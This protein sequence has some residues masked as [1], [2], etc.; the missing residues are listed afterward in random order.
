MTPK[1][2][3]FNALNDRPIDRTPTFC[4]G[5]SQTVTVESMEAIGVYWP[6]AHSDP[7]MMAELSASTYDLTGLEIA[8]VPYC[9]SVEA[10]ALGCHTDF[11]TRRDSIPQ[12]T[13]TPYTDF[14]EV[15]VPEN[16]LEAK[17]VPVV[18]EAISILKEQ[19]GDTLPVVAG[20]TGP[21]TLA[22]H[23]A[24]IE[25]MLKGLIRKPDKY[26]G[27]IELA[28]EIGSIYGRALMEAG[29][30][31]VSIADPSASSDIISPRMFR[32]IVKPAI[33]K[34]VETIGGPSFLHICG[35][36]TP[37]LGDM[38]E[39]GVDSISI[40]DKVDARQAKELVSGKAKI[41]GNISTTVTLLLKG[42]GDVR[43][44]C[45]AA[46]EA[47]VDILA[48]SCGIAPVTPNENIK[49]LVEAAKSYPSS[50]AGA[51]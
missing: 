6:E 12:V 34:M 43:E 46:I 15:E 48:P 44:E 18:L 31:V 1:E 40:S 45:V 4:S 5:C 19:V 51:P 36:C 2:R 23:L 35:N 42:P 16:L 14:D 39:T 25:P 10:E 50:R 37:I 8:G 22:G 49:A 20:M 13:G 32:G 30:D 28:T 11:G 17:R 24:A 29:A 3:L 26:M 47:G 33:T 21:F 38:A 9:L 41:T 27:F 7:D